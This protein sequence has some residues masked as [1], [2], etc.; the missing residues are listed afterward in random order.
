MKSKRLLNA[1]LACTFLCAL[2]SAAQEQGYWRAQSSN[3]KSITGDLNFSATKFT[4]NFSTYTLAQI[5]T[6][7]PADARALFN[8]DDPSAGAE[9]LY[10]LSI[11]D[12]KRFLH[13]N[14][15]CGGEETD[16]IIT[17]IEGRDL[18]LAFFSGPSIPTLT[19]EAMADNPRLCGVF[20]Y[21]R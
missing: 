21:Q 6:L 9:N 1:A 8:P 11:P 4:I 19:P 2:S 12:T 5:R 17:Y 7:Q 15:L 10:R 13:H 18:Q 14:T 20:S 3:A 16:W